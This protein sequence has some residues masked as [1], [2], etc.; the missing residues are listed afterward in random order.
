MP[1][2]LLPDVGRRNDV[3]RVKLASDSKLKYAKDLVEAQ[4]REALHKSHV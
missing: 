1:I 2:R 3:A 4:Y